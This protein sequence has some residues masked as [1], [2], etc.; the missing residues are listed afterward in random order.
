MACYASSSAVTRARGAVIS[1]SS[2]SILVMASFNA[3][4]RSGTIIEWSIDCITEWCCRHRPACYRQ[5]IKPSGTSSSSISCC[6]RL[7]GLCVPDTASGTT[8]CASCE[9]PS[10][11]GASRSSTIQLN[12]LEIVAL[13]G[14]S[15]LS[16]PR[17]FPL[18]DG[19]TMCHTELLNCYKISPTAVPPLANLIMFKNC[20]R[21]LRYGQT[22]PHN[23]FDQIRR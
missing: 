17:R 13:H 4:V 1:V 2:V 18:V 8:A 9:N 14:Q 11:F 21:C 23:R 6:V 10:K 20:H 15:R 3:P 16:Y 22:T 12:L 7:P 19:L 5:R